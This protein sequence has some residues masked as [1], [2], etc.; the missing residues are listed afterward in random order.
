M[1]RAVCKRSNYR[2]C[3][4]QRYWNERIFFLL[5]PTHHHSLQTFYISPLFYTPWILQLYPDHC[6]RDAISIYL[7]QGYLLLLSCQRVFFKERPSAEKTA[8]SMKALPIHIW[9][10]DFGLTKPTWGPGMVM[11]DCNTRNTQERNRWICGTRWLARL[12]K[13]IS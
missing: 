8:Q 10:P 1:P 12:V 4:A 11:R 9:K 5:L 7:P 3:L 13:L 2:I 6:L